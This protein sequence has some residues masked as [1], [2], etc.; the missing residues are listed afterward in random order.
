MEIFHDFCLPNRNAVAAP[1]AHDKAETAVAVVRSVAKNHVLDTA[2]GV[3]IRILVA[4]P[5]KP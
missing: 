5:F 2:G 4:T 1:T 3:V